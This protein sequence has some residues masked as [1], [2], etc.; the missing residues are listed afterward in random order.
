M[1]YLGD[2][3][4][5]KEIFY[6]YDNIVPFPISPQKI[7]KAG[8]NVSS[9]LLGFIEA[10]QEADDIEEYLNAPEF[11]ENL[12]KYQ[13]SI[14]KILPHDSYLINL[15]SPDKEKREKSLK[16]FLDEAKRCEK[17]GLIYL[18]LHPGS[19]LGQI[20]ETECI[21][22]IVNSL[23]YTLNETE[24]ISLIIENTAGQGSNIGYR[25][26]HIRDIIDGIQNKNR[27]GVCLDT[28]HTYTSGYDITTKEKY[29]E[30]FLLF[31]K[32]V[33]E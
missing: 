23:N 9:Y 32:I 2:E 3:M 25:F 22:N 17:L 28:C 27:V 13:Y 19:H 1:N 6:A 4:T 12:E 8:F 29:D 11:K 5:V 21:K 15:G 31:D 24:F 26:E 10:L 18:N 14:D 20:S 16:S 33:A 7:R 30:T